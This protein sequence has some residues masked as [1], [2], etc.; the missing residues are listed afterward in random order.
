MCRVPPPHQ[1]L[2]RVSQ[3]N[4]TKVTKYRKVAL[5][6]AKNTKQ[7]VRTAHAQLNASV[8]SH[9]DLQDQLELERKKAR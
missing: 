6:T 1:V 9:E 5:A 8:L 3:I 2:R 4:V 7:V